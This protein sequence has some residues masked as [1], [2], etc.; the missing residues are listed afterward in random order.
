MGTGI[1]ELDALVNDGKTAVS[2]IRRKWR[3][4]LAGAAVAVAG[5]LMFIYAGRSSDALKVGVAI[6]VVGVL[7]M[8]G[9]GGITWVVRQLWSAGKKIPSPKL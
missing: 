7:M 5:G 6:I 9:S 1:D 4:K 3:M 2:D 8:L